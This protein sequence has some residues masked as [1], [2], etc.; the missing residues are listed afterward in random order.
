MLDKYSVPMKQTIGQPMKKFQGPNKGP[1][2]RGSE[3]TLFQSLFW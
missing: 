2:N 1:V 3:G